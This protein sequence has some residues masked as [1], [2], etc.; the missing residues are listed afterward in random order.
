MAIS[1]ELKLGILINSG[2]KAIVSGVSLFL[3]KW[4]IRCS[5]YNDV[6]MV[7]GTIYILSVE[8]R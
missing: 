3:C 6:L 2:N 5:I 8:S 7:Q 1:L 4:C